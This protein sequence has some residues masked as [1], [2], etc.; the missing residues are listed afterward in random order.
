MILVSL[1][2]R[3]CASLFVLPSSFANAAIV[4]CLVF[5]IGGCAKVICLAFRDYELPFLWLVI[6][7]KLFLQL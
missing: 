1:L 7:L 6:V 4:I 2:S 5:C 3:D